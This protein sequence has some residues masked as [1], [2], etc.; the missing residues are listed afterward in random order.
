MGRCDEEGYYYITGRKKNVII[1]HN[2]ENVNPE[3]IEAAFGRCEAIEECLVFGDGKGICADVY[4]SSQEEAA[5]FIRSYNYKMPKYRQVYKVNYVA[6]PLPRTG[7]GK[8]K[9]KENVK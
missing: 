8:I 2:G 4:A 6:E 3:E 1:L 9:R 7:T 5:A